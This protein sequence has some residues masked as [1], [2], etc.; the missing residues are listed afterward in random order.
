MLLQNLEK[1]KLIHPPDWLSCN[2]MYLTIMGSE[3]YGCASDL[4]D[5]DVYGF[6]IPPKNMVFPHLAGHIH[7]FGRQRQEFDQWQQHAVK[8]TSIVPEGLTY[9]MIVTELKNRGIE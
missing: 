3:A 4:S 5:K 1:R 7:N 2:T 9:E 8:D 6:A